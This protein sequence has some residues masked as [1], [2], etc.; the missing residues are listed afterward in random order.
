MLE[1]TFE[2]KPQGATKYDTNKARM[3]LIPPTPLLELGK[4]Y[5]KG[6]D[7]YSAHNWE[8][9][10]DWGRFYAA[11][12]RHLLSWWKG[13]RFDPDDGQHHLIA[14]IWNLIA[15][16]EFE[17][18]NIGNDDRLASNVYVKDNT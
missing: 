5:A 7:K 12:Q 8:L 13:E 18:L 14:A 11:S 17:R 10:A 9:G 15:L 6:A 1:G 2:V 16:Y 3:D 4:L